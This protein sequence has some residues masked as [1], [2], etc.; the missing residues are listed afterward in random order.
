MFPFTFDIKFYC[1]KACGGGCSPVAG[2]KTKWDGVIITI[3]DKKAIFK[4]HKR[5]RTIDM[6]KS[7]KK[8]RIREFDVARVFAVIAMVAVHTEFAIYNYENEVFAIF[9]DYLGSPFAAPVFM[10]ILGANIFLSSKNSPRQ[11]LARGISTFSSSVVFNIICHALPFLILD[12]RNQTTNYAENVLHWVFAVDILTFSALA[13][14][15]FALIRKLNLNNYV[16][17][18]IGIACSLINIILTY[19]FPIDF[20]GHTI[21][22]IITGLFYNSSITGYFSFLSWIIFPIAGYI[23]VQILDKVVDKNKFYLKVGGVCIAAYLAMVFASYKWLPQL[24]FIEFSEEYSYYQMHPFN[25]IG[26]VFFCIGW[27]SIMYFA[28]KILPKG[29]DCHIARWNRNLT[30]IYMIQW[31]LIN[32]C[33]VLP[34]NNTFSVN[35]WQFV[36]CFVAVI[37]ASD[38]L[39]ML[40]RKHKGKCVKNKSEKFVMERKQNK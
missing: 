4:K 30:V 12:F 35:E 9:F 3:L 5:S 21:A 2:I 17:A 15:F 22:A 37:I 31:F 23:F 40:Y 1:L 13:F 28:S 6:S 7:I 29:L 36:I 10:F 32:Y 16:L 19:N 8:E 33:F 25:A 24:P 14:M 39:L 27:I 38:I 26:T 34:S 11:L 20:D 18:A